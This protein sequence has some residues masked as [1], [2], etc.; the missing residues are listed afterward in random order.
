VEGVVREVVGMDIS[1][2]GAMVGVGFCCVGLLREGG[3]FTVVCAD[4]HSCSSRW[5]VVQTSFHVWIDVRQGK[6]KDAVEAEVLR[7]WVSSLVCCWTTEI[8][9]GEISFD[10]D[11]VNCIVTCGSLA[12]SA[13]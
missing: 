9:G 12:Q 1:A 11:I 13:A 3:G 6:E 10:D 7:K 2:G 5:V 8:G 4:W